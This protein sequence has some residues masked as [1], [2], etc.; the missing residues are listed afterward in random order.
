MTDYLKT[1]LAEIRE[2]Y[3]NADTIRRLA[4]IASL[5]LL[6]FALIMTGLVV[7]SVA[8]D[9]FFY[10]LPVLVVGGAIVWFMSRNK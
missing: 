9:L 10:V 2:A 7:V 3:E 8:V 6:A 4:M 5:A 1:K